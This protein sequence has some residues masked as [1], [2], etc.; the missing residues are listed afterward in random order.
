MEVLALLLPV[1]QADLLLIAKHFKMQQP[2]NVLFPKMD[3]LSL[4]TL[5]LLVLKVNI[6][7]MVLRVLILLEP[8]ELPLLIV[9]HILQLLL[10]LVLLVNQDMLLK[11]TELEL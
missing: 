3:I 2:L 4:V 1:L 8:Q 11:V 10:L 5:L 9:K 7:P 6:Q